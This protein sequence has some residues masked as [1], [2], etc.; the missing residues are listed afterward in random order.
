MFMN[1]FFNVLLERDHRELDA[2]MD[3]ANEGLT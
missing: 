1:L 3:T 2:S